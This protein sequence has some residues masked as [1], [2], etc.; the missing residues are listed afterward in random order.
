[1]FKLCKNWYLILVCIIY[2]LSYFYR[3]SIGPIADVLEKEFNTTSTGIGMLSSFL[4]G[5]YFT[6]Q[7]VV[8]LLLEIYSFHILILFSS[9][10]LGIS[11]IIFSFTSNVTMGIIIRFISGFIVAPPYV[12]GIAMAS[13][14][15]GDDYVSMY[16]G[17]L[18]FC[19]NLI[20]FISQCIQAYIYDKYN[21]WKSVYLFAGIFSI[22]VSIIFFIF[23]IYEY[24]YEYKPNKT[25][26]LLL[27][28][29]KQISL[30]PNTDY[31]SFQNEV[32]FVGSETDLNDSI[33]F[34]Q[35]LVYRQAERNKY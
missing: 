26:G 6:M 27:G 12:T 35:F 28:D 7:V 32:D 15:F 1:M 5:S 24:L 4:Y 9:S 8:G 21:D 16:S 34:W 19:G 17:I 33:S 14:L 3:N 23:T 13:Q 11:L 20:V 10:F 2:S 22:F 31:N 18:F 29:I 25:N 30:Q